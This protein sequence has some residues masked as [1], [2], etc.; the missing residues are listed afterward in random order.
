MKDIMR[1]PCLG[2]KGGNKNRRAWTGNEPTVEAIRKILISY[3]E[4]T[5][6]AISRE[7]VA[8][9]NDLA[10][11]ATHG[12]A[13]PI[14]E[15][16]LE[17][18]MESNPDNYIRN[19]SGVKVLKPFSDLVGYPMKLYQGMKIFLTQNVNK[20]YDYVN[21]MRATV[22]HYDPNSKGLRV[23]TDS[24]H[25]IVVAPWTDRE[26]GNRTYYPIRPGY[27]STILKFQGSTLK[28]VVVWLDIPEIEGAGSSFVNINRSH[29]QTIVL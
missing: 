14:F 7:S 27:A 6:L 15:G 13:T 20:E 25:R 8:K 19:A 10:V 12:Q 9:L 5:L 2:P 28:H 11:Q 3:P 29:L 16:V 4:T 1:G 22:E 18:D 21:G 24:G 26:K 17:G 23:I